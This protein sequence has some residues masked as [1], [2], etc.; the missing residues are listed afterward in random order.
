MSWPNMFCNNQRLVI[1]TISTINALLL[2]ELNTNH[3]AN[4]CLELLTI[5]RR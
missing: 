4:T 5:F 1:A 3:E 2:H